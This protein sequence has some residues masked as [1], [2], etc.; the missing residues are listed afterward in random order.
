MS[1]ACPA[2]PH[3]QTTYADSQCGHELCRGAH[4]AHYAGQ[5]LKSKERIYIPI[6]KAIYMHYTNYIIS[7]L[8]MRTC[9]CTSLYS[10]GKNCTN[11]SIIIHLQAPF[12][13]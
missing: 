4:L 7:Q 11:G 2:L 9:Y 6:L 13:L 1:V 8:V 10:K 12:W 5:N 3:T